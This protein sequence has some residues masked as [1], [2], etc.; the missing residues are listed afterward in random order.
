MRGPGGA[1]AERGEWAGVAATGWTWSAQFGD[2][3]NDGFLDLYAVNGMIA[4]EIFGHLPGAELVEENQALRNDGSGRFVPAPE[5][6]LGATES[7]GGMAFADLDLDGDLDIVVNNLEAPALLFENRLCGG[8]GLEVDLRWLGSPNPRA[9]GAGVRLA[10]AAATY[11]R[12]VQ[13]TCRPAA[14]TCPA[15]PRAST[16]A[17]PPPR[18]SP[19]TLTVTWP[20][21][22]VTRSAGLRPRTPGHHRT[23]THR[24][25]EALR[26]TA[27]QRSRARQPAFVSIC[28]A[29]GMIGHGPST[30]SAPFGACEGRERQWLKLD[31]RRQQPTSSRM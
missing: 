14:A 20:D 2:L 25:P 3:D 28:A 9:I 26:R 22:A 10:T 29:S 1:F 23:L 13:A 19:S 11:L 4:A 5:W 21:G 7:G 17:C 18:P 27:V 16:S 24:C 31:N 8:A 30:E 15:P 6:G 12:T